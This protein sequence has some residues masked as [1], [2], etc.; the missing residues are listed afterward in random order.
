MM[1]LHLSEEKAKPFHLRNY[2][3]LGFCGLKLKLLCRW[4]MLVYDELSSLSI[5]EVYELFHSH[6]TQIPFIS[7]SLRLFVL[8]SSISIFHRKRK[9]TS[10]I[11]NFLHLLLPR[12]SLC[13]MNETKKKTLHVMEN[14]VIFHSQNKQIYFMFKLV[15]FFCLSRS[16]FFETKK[17]RRR[18]KK[19]MENRN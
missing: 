17:K 7:I 1:K 8:L 18:D 5:W 13:L 9:T 12:S 19:L 11:I 3:L 15:H 10:V 14:C 6:L 4:P 2:S 16:Q